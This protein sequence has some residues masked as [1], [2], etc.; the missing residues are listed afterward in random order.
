MAELRAGV[1]EDAAELARLFLESARAGFGDLLPP[2]YAWPSAEVIEERTRAAMTEQAVGLIVADG[3]EGLLGYVGHSPSRDAD[4]SASVGEVRTMFVSPSA[5]GS[6]VGD[7]LI[8]SSFD[9]LTAAGYADATVWTFADN[10]RANA[11][12]AK[13]GMVP[14]GAR[15]REA[16]W[17]DIDEVRYRRPLE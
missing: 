13:H 5:W 10:G 8:E 7:R 14:D 16:V 4:A 11:F 2:D 15:R 9:A 3:P 6:G 17:A 1:P 12:Y